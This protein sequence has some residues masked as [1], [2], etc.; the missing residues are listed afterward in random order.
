M[1]S[2]KP[3]ISVTLGSSFLVITYKKRGKSPFLYVTLGTKLEINQGM[4]LKF[5]F[6]KYVLTF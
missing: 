6:L 4:A 3:I 5:Y 1:M 2:I